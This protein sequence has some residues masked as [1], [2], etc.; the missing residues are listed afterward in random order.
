YVA[1]SYVWG[2]ASSATAMLANIAAL[3]APGALDGQEI[4]ATIQEAMD[5]TRLLGERYLWVDR[6]YIV[7]DDEDAK[8]AQLR[9]MADIYA[10]ALL[11]IVAAQ[12]RGAD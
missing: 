11:T 7:Q 12:G 3:Q 5:L 2:Q 1:L 10:G 8:H 4:P 6:L 9:G